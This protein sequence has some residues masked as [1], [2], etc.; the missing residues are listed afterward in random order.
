MPP[1]AYH[2]IRVTCA[3][4]WHARACKPR[5]LARIRYMATGVVIITAFAGSLPFREVHSGSPLHHTTPCTRGWIRKCV[6]DAI[7][8]TLNVRTNNIRLSN[9]LLHST[10]RQGCLGYT[11]AGALA[12]IT[13]DKAPLYRSLVTSNACQKSYLDT[14]YASNWQCLYKCR[15]HS[16]RWPPTADAVFVSHSVRNM[17]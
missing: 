1:P 14:F 12:S 4:T 6:P 10:V 16:S 15:K 2:R 11:G 17:Q 3:R 8:T 9:Q 13:G 5:V 7:N